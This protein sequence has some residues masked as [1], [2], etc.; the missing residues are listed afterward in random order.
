VYERVWV[1]R[2]AFLNWRLVNW[3]TGNTSVGR[4]SV[5]WLIR[6]N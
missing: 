6:R 4:V 2:S 5:W 3:I 1:L